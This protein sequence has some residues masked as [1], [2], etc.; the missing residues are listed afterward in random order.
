[1]N[2][3]YIE[4]DK[5]ALRKFK[6]YN[7]WTNVKKP[8]NENGLN[9]IDYISIYVKKKFPNDVVIGQ[10]FEFNNIDIY[11]IEEVLPIEVQSTVINTK[12]GITISTFEKACRNQIEE[13]IRTL[14][15]CWFFFDEELLRY[16]K[17]D[18]TNNSNVQFDWLYK[19][20]KEEKLKVFTLN[21]R[22][23]INER[24]LSDFNFISKISTTCDLGKDNDI[25]IL[26]RNKYE[27]LKTLIKYFKITQ[28]EIDILGKEYRE[29]M[30]IK[31][32]SVNTYLVQMIKDK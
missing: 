3:S 20:M 7:I 9:A 24:V 31:K 4:E 16:L 8:F 27:I 12:G 14:G 6:G 29:N 23:E 13:N 2:S 17:T 30:K 10:Y 26:N 1:M 5:F 25:R 21:Y 18:I 11:V 15:K 22:G 19:L 32:V 28:F